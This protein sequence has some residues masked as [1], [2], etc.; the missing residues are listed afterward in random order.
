MS[1]N[2]NASEDGKVLIVHIQQMNVKELSVKMEANVL[3]HTMNTSVSANMDSKVFKLF[4]IHSSLSLTLDLLLGDH[5]EINIDECA[6]SPCKNGGNC[7]DLINGFECHCQPGY[8]G[9][10]CQT[11]IDECA[12]QP[13]SR[14][15]F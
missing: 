3:M 8:K 12:L 7:T 9:K 1:T 15:F 10:F 4:H 6:S 11:D 2:V 13:V 5:C 14:N